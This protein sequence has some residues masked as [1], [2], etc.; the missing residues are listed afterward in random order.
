MFRNAFLSSTSVSARSSCGKRF[1]RIHVKLD[2]HPSSQYAGIHLAMQK[3]LYKQ[4]GLDVILTKPGEHGG[5]EPKVV[6]D[7]QTELDNA[8]ETDSISIGIVEQ[9]VLIPAIGNNVNVKAFASIFQMT[10][11]IL[12]GL[13]GINLGSIG[14]LKDF[15]IGMHIDSTELM[16]TIIFHSNYRTSTVQTVQRADKMDKLLAGTVNAIQVSKFLKCMLFLCRLTML[17]KN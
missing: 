4:N 17:I 5:D 7:K 9:N 3:N 8:G 1:L 14:E 11:L 15:K 10:P 2:Y 13:P 6:V 12:L 16:K